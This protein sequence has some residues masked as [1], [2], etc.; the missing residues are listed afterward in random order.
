MKLFFPPPHIFGHFFRKTEKNMVFVDIL[1]F[2]HHMEKQRKLY[3]FSSHYTFLECGICKGWNRNENHLRKTT[4][5]EEC[6]FDLS[7]LIHHI[8]GYVTKT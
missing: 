8:S 4:T 6:N 2:F 7:L 1:F 5:N 3:D